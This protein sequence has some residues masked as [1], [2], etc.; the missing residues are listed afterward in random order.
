M[1]DDTAPQIG[2]ADVDPE[3]LT[4]DGEP[5]AELLA[6]LG[7]ESTAPADVRTDGWRVLALLSREIE[8]LERESAAG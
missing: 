4:G 7:V 1:S 3:A 6:R 8:E 5:L 2:A